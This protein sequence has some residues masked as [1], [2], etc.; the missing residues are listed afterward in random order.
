LTNKEQRIWHEGH[1][2]I[3]DYQEKTDKSARKVYRDR[4]NRPKGFYFVTD[5]AEF[6]G[7]F[8][9][10]EEAKEVH[11]QHMREVHGIYG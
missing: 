2:L 6:Y 9:T 11:Q 7:P 3:V 10:Q 1:G 4:Y 5:D 8:D